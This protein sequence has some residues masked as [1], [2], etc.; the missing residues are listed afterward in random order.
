MTTRDEHDGGQPTPRRG[1][2]ARRRRRRPTPASASG[3][4]RARV[5]LATRGDTHVRRCPSASTPPASARASTSTAPSATRRS[6]PLPGRAR[7]RRLPRAARAPSTPRASCATTRCTSASTRRRSSPV[8]PRARRRR[9]GPVIAVPR[10][11]AAPRRGLT[12]SPGVVVAALLTV[13][14]IAVVG[15]YLGRPAPALHQ[16]ADPRRHQPAVAALDRRRG[17]RLVHCSRARRSRAG[18]SP[19]RSADASPADDADSTGAWSMEVD[20]AA[21]RTSSRSAPPTRRPASSPSRRPRSS[22]PCR[23]AEIEA[24]TLTVDQPADG[25]TFENGAIP[26]QGTTTNATS[27]VGD[28]ALRRSARRRAAAAPRRRR[29]P[30]GPHR[31]GP[32]RRGRHVQHAARADDRPLVDHVTATGAARGR[33][34]RSPA[35]S[36]SPTRA[37]TSS[38]RSRAG[39]PGSRSGSTASSIRTGPA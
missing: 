21:A 15:A 33:P 11:L 23:S 29:R 8:A 4:T 12:F 26:V 17:R 28:G 30:P 14:V 16:A 2:D 38:S 32:G 35:T 37:S 3:G 36:P 10:P 31:H 13:V 20:S 5:D 39:R 7:A 1:R 24:P 6:G 19:S 9:A 25:A 22:S 34:P 27:V 18:R